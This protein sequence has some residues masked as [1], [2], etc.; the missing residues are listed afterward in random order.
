MFVFGTGETGQLGL[1]D[2]M[3]E[4]KRPM[5]LAALKESEIVD[6]ACGGMHSVALS[7]QGQVKH[8]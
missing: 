1:T 2:D 5:P 6:I 3:L 7:K 4:R 8:F